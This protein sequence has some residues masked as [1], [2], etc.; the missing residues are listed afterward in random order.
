MPEQDDLLE[1]P[2]QLQ[3]STPSSFPSLGKISTFAVDSFTTTDGSLQQPNAS[4]GNA[5]I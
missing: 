1:V 2:K 3:E 4:M 5:P